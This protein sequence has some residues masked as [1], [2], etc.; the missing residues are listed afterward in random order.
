M[1]HERVGIGPEFSQYERHALSHQSGDECDVA[2]KALS[3]ALETRKINLDQLATH[4]F[5]ENK[6][7]CRLFDKRNMKKAVIR[8][9][10][11]G[12]GKYKA[13]MDNIGILGFKQPSVR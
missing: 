8:A 7:A 2:G 1:Q 5:D 4:H 10:L 6:T 11:P 13:R 3:L 12:G 9:P